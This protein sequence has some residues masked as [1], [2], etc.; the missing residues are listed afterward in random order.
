MR[1]FR[2]VVF[3]ADFRTVACLGDELLLRHEEIRDKAQK[4]VFEAL[5]DSTDRFPF[6]TLGIDSDNGSEFIN[7]Q[8]LRYCEQNQITFTR[9]RPGNKN[10]GCH[11]EQKNWD[12]ARRPSATTGT[13]PRQSRIC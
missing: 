13:T 12:V 10:D 8:L 1:C 9:S 11:V 6:P 7:H 3:L 2:I 4:W 5:K